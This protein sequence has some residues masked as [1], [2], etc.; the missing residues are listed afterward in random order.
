MEVTVPFVPQRHVFCTVYEHVNINHIHCEM[1]QRSSISST[2]RAAII[3][4]TLDICYTHALATDFQCKFRVL[5]E[6]VIFSL[7]RAKSVP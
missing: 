7:D 2:I 5:D 3:A 4:A 1:Q 6:I